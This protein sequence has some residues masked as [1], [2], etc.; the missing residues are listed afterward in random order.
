M[1]RKKKKASIVEGF[2][3]PIPGVEHEVEMVEVSAAGVAISRPAIPFVLSDGLTQCNHHLRIDRRQARALRG[4][5]D[6]LQFE[7]ATY[8]SMDTRSVKGGK[9]REIRTQLDAIRFILDLVA[10]DMERAADA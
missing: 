7:D 8:L 6:A 3:P 1:G 2:E 5:F 10:E 9:R 4:V